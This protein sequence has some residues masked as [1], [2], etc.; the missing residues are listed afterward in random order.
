MPN[1]V[2]DSINID[3][4]KDP[5]PNQ[6]EYMK[7]VI[8][9][10]NKKQNALLESPTGTGKTLSLLCATIAWQQSQVVNKPI[11]QQTNQSVNQTSNKDHEISYV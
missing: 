7:K 2:I 6:V 5:Y 8:E 3:F 10:L 1:I 11:H 9:A 4:P